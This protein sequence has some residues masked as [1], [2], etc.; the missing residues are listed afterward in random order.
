[1]NN[2]SS[3]LTTPTIGNISNINSK[4]N[5]N[6]SSNTNNILSNTLQRQ[7]NTPSFYPQFF[8]INRLSRPQSLS[9]ISTN[10]ANTINNLKVSA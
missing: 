6:D 5:S 9:N 8:Q 3:N 1:M 4:I 10:L 2:P 7:I